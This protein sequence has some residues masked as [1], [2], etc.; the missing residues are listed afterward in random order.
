[1]P[2]RPPVPSVADLARE[3]GLDLRAPGDD[4]AAPVT[5]A[6]H[7]SRRVRP[8]DLYAALP[9][10]RVHGSRFVADA[11]A[12][13]AVTVLTDEAGAVASGS[14]RVPLLVAADARAVLGPVAAAVHG[15]P[16][17]DLAVVGVT[18]TNGKTTV[19]WLLH[20][21]LRSTGVGAGLIGTVAVRVHDDEVPSSMTTPEA[22]DLQAT[23]AAM[24]DAGAAVVALEVSS[25]ALALHR[26]DGTHMAVVGFTNLSRDHLDFHGDMESYL[27]AKMRLFTGG[28]ADRAV[29][30]TDDDAGRRVADTARAAGMDVWTLSTVGTPADVV[31]RGADTGVDGRQR[32]V[33]AGPF[34]PGGRHDDLVL[35]VPMPGRH[36][37]ANA[38]TALALALRTAEA[39][40]GHLEGVPD[41]YPGALARA[42]S[43]FPGVPG[44]MERVIDPA[45]AGRTPL[46]VVDY[47]HTPDAV[48]TAVESLRAATPGRLVVVLGAG[49]ARD[50]GKRGPMGAA[51]AAGADVVVVTDD[52]PRGEDPAAIRSAVLA[53]AV[54]APHRR[55]GDVVECADRAAAIAR[56]LACCTGPEDTVLVT[57]KGHETG[58]DYGDGRREPF[59]DREAA[60]RALHAWAAE[61]GVRRAVVGRGEAPPAAGTAPATMQ[62]TGVG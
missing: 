25:H 51:A 40:A 53:G 41:G 20:H 8:G 49:G 2:I 30:C 12:A 59:D 57:G 11:V 54:S 7:D 6:T 48:T 22:T 10:E 32:V 44:R 35:D 43:A 31:L 58:Q 1:V 45:S 18:G 34:G 17:D 60:A 24:R 13:G 52:N 23:L 28:F 19:T 21:L 15:R 29:V 56:A 9:G 5:G 62:G 38:V 27:A 16:G 61:A 37:A 4:G 46:V 55:A 26:V 39:S 3:F 42:V 33:A 47:A 50:Q 36:N 14:P